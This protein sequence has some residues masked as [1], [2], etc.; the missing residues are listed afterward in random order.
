MFML[1]PVRKLKKLEMHSNANA[2]EGALAPNGCYES[3]EARR[4]ARGLFAVGSRLKMRL[5]NINA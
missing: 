2:P 1:S 5:R 4:T 3:G